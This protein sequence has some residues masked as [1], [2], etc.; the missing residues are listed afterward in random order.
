[1]EDAE[2]GLDLRAVQE[3]QL[4]RTPTPC[5]SVSD[6]TVSSLCHWVAVLVVVTD[7]GI[8]Q[9]PVE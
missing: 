2:R 7:W 1:M 5:D 4:N 3:G 6:S 9:K 8:S